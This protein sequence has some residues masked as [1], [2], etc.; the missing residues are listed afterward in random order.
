[1]ARLPE[2]KLIL[3]WLPRNWCFRRTLA[4]FIGN[5]RHAAKVVWPGRTFLLRM[6]DLLSCFRKKGHPIWLKKEFHL[7]LQW[8]DHLL[9]Q[10]HD[11]SFWLYPG[12]SPVVDL[13]VASDAAG[14]LGFGAYFKGFWFTSLWAVSQ[15]KQSTAYKE[16]FPVV[17]AAHV[18]GLQWCKKHVLFRSDNKAVV[19]ILNSRTSKIPSLM[20]FSAARCSFSFSGQHILA[21]LY[22]IADALSRFRWQEFRQLA[23]GAQPTQHRFFPSFYRNWPVFLQNSSVTPSLCMA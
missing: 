22:Q 15:Q 3:S 12:L 4:S 17:V 6:V 16:L 13:E 21:V 19:Q 5:L 14:S 8:W 20:Q 18:W 9:A 2:G 10:W 23:P 7:D 11:V 1:M